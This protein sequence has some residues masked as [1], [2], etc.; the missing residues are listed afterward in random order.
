MRSLMCVTLTITLL[1]VSKSI[2]KDNPAYS[3]ELGKWG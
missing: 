1:V 2:F 3:T